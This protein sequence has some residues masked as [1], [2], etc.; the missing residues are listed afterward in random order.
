MTIVQAVTLQHTICDCSL[1]QCLGFV[2]VI[3]GDDGGS[4]GS[5]DY[6]QI[7]ASQTVYDFLWNEVCQSV[8]GGGLCRGAWILR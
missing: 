4:A 3:P 5:L 6:E 7:C 8:C 1:L 2:I